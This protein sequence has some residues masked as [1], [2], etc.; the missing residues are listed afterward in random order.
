MA[1]ATAKAGPLRPDIKLSQALSDYEAVL[2]AEQ[3]QIYKKSPPDAQAVMALTCEID[4]QNAGRRSRRCGAR[5]TSFLNSVKGFTSIVDLIVSSSGN[6]IAGG[7]WGAVRFAIQVG[8]M[9]KPTYFYTCLEVYS[10]SCSLTH[11]FI[12]SVWLRNLFR[13]AFDFVD[14]RWP[15]LTS[16]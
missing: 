7:V 14:E 13:L 10:F 11:S 3:R 4:R 16:I 2:S 12:D 5:L 8:T 1:L 6:P 9:K 15:E